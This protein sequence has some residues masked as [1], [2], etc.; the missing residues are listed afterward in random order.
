M[1]YDLAIQR[2]YLSLKDTYTENTE[3]EDFYLKKKNS[4]A[5]ICQKH[6]DVVGS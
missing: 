5:I 1:T 6:K 4:E 2:F 3:K